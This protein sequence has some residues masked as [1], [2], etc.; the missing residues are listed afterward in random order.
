MKQIPLSNGDFA[1]VDDED[2][3]R[4]MAMG[5]WW[6]DKDG[7]AVKSATFRAEN[8]IKKSLKILM[9]REILNVPIGMITDHING[10]KVDNRKS[11][12]RKCNF[13]E[14]ARNY[15]TPKNN[16]SGFKGVVWNKRDKKWFAR[17]TVFRK[18]IY[19]GYFDCK[20]KAARAYNEAAIKYHKE[21][22]KLNIIPDA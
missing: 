19:L 4:L 22:A 8:G 20:I 6:V 18:K 1:L 15:P 13:H 12:L 9:H 16:T 2:F 5:K 14:N 3:D 10:N 7:Y 17:I 21:F 11:N